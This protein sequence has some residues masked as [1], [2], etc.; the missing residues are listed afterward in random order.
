MKSLYLECNATTDARF[1]TTDAYAYEMSAEDHRQ[2]LEVL[3]K[4]KGKVMASG[5][6]SALYDETLAGW[7]RHTFDLPNNAAGGLAKAR[8]TEVLWCNF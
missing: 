3:I 8:E 6:P 5:Y 7:N 2:L 4:C 1:S